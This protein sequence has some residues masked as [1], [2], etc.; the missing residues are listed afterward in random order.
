[1]G[2]EVLWI[3]TVTRVSQ[4]FAAASL[5]DGTFSKENIRKSHLRK[6]KNWDFPGGPV[7]KT[8]CSQCRGHGFDP[9]SGN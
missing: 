7:V 8:Q 5:I 2:T 9:W 1:M 4:A 3:L 6:R